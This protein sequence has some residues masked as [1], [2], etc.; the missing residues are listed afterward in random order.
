MPRNVT[1]AEHLEGRKMN[2]EFIA[3]DIGFA[4]TLDLLCEL[5]RECRND[6]DWYKLPFE[7]ARISLLPGLRGIE[8]VDLDKTVASLR[9]LVEDL[10]RCRTQERSAA[11]LF[12][13]T[14]KL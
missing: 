4:R 9:A 12:N 3:G 2:L 7:P 14:R 6:P 13:A 11:A 10:E 8:V 1:L 5:H